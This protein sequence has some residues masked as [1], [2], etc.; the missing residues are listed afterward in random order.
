MERGHGR[1]PPDS[2]QIITLVAALLRS[3]RAAA[4]YSKEQQRIFRTIC[5][6]LRAMRQN[7]ITA[8]ETEDSGSN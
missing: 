6:R 1:E 4:D 8:A 5:R 2:N 3:E 7:Q